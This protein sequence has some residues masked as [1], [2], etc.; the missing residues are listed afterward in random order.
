MQ[1]GIVF[2]YENQLSRHNEFEVD[3]NQRS[4]NQY[5]TV[6]IDDGTYPLSHIKEKYLN[7]PLL[8]KFY[9][10]VVNVSTGVTVDYFVGWKDLTKLGSVELRSYSISPKLYVGWTLKVGKA[11]KL[12][13]RF[14]LEPEIWFNPLFDYEYSYSGVAVKLKYK[15]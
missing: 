5:L 11:I 3:L 12:S 7:L 4:R 1:T 14:I 13:P 9:S 2:S 8:Y 10:K 6:P 15:L